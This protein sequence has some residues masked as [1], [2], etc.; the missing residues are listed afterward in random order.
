MS[1][2]VP[3]PQL[4][5]AVALTFQGD[6]GQ[7][8]MHRICGW[9]CQEMGDRTGPGSRIGIWSGRGGADAIEAVLTGRVDVA[10]MTPSASAAMIQAGV[11]PLAV[12]GNK[13]L[14]VLGTLPQRDRLVT[15]IDAR[16]GVRTHEDLVDVLSRL[17]IATSPDDGV[18]LIGLAAH[19]LL[20]AAGVEPNEVERAG[21][22]F[23][24]SERPRPAIEAFSGGSANVLIHEAIMTPAWRRV[25]ERRPVA[26]L[27]VSAP[28]AETL[29][30]WLWPTAMVEKDYLPGLDHEL[31][32]LEFSDFLLLCTDD[33]PEDVAAL[34]AWCLV[35]TR[36]SL[37]AQYAHHPPERSPVGYPLDPRRIASAPLSL[38]PA[39]AAMYAQLGVDTDSYW[40]P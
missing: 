18:N 37:E 19:A 11:G 39:A 31:R 13:R 30:K 33:L 12:A 35:E 2:P 8:N 5:R 24:Y 20:R 26:Y 4:N 32:A 17:R 34:L 27:D 3:A 15:C 7:A 1:W 28:M 23:L 38:H 16:L 6:W 9:L 10:V 36:T 25:A 21:G 22:R 29:E 14:R 40:E